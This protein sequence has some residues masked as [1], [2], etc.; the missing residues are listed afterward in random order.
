MYENRT[1]F[2]NLFRYIH[3]RIVALLFNGLSIK[4]PDILAKHIA[5]IRG[6]VH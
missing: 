1:E 6:N 4:F 3:P 5:A 2:F